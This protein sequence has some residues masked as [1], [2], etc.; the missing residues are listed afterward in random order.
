MPAFTPP[1]PRDAAS[2]RSASITM[3][4]RMSHRAHPDNL[5]VLRTDGTRRTDP[6]LATHRP[7]VR[8]QGHS[9]LLTQATRSSR[10]GGYLFAVT[11]ESAPRDLVVPGSSTVW[12]ERLGP[13]AFR[14]SAH[15]RSRSSTSSEAGSVPGLAR[16]VEASARG[17]CLTASQN[18][19][20]ISDRVR[21][22]SVVVY[23]ATG[24]TRTP[25][26]PDSPAG[27]DEGARAWSC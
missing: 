3:T 1:T 26:A 10:S 19:P 11:V 20:R 13:A 22:S 9:R 14:T 23:S 6:I 15:R 18:R 21:T 12:R 25:G 8:R 4:G 5:D 16:K 7:E 27:G 24:R 17:A 2:T